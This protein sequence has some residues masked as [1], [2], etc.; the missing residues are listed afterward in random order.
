MTGASE[1]FDLARDFEK[2]PAK[3]ASG[4]FDAYRGAGEGFRDDWQHNARASSGSHAA[5]YPDSIST[6][7]KFAGFNIE[8][9]TGP[10]D[11]AR[12][13]GFLGRV[14]E[15]GGEHSSPHLDGLRAMPLAAARLDR[16]ADAAIG[17]ALP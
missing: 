2:S 11:G 15:F 9:E 8:V 1:I 16:L 13:Q 17:L 10:E 5:K 4:L 12:N 3:V 7:M 6:E 14:L